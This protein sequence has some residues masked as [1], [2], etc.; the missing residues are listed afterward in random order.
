[1]STSEIQPAG[2]K[3]RQKF[4]RGR[5]A[6]TALDPQPSD[7]PEDPLNWPQWKKD[8]AFGS[9]VLGTAVTGMYKT[10]LVTVGSVLRFQLD[11][12]WIGITALTGL[13]IMLGGL[14]GLKSIA[15][16]QLIGKRLLY[17]L[18]ALLL[19][20]S[21]YW[22]MH[23]TGSYA[24]FMMSRVLAGICWGTY[25][26]LINMSMK[27][28][29]FVH[30]RSSRIAILNVTSIIFTWGSP[31]IGGFISQR[32]DGFHN[33]VKIV[34]IIQS[35]SIIFL[36]LIT[37]ETTFKRAA[38]NSRSTVAVE[39]TI[40]TT[41]PACVGLKLY[42]QS[43]RPIHPNAKSKFQLSKALLPFRALC[44]PTVILTFLMT[45]PLV[46]SAFA[47]ALIIALLFS[48]SPI[49]ALPTQIGLMFT[50]PL[51]ASLIAYG[52]AALAAHIR[53]RPPNHISATCQNHLGIA[54]PG[55]VLGFSGILGFGLYVE[56][57][58]RPVTRK[59]GEVFALYVQGRD[60]N[61][62]IASLLFGLLVSGA[63]LINFSASNHMRA[64]TS[65]VESDV[66][67]GAHTTLQNLLTGI[68]VIG[69][70]IWIDGN[71]GMSFPGLKNAA[72]ALGVVQIFISS[73]VTALLWICGDAIS[74]LDGRVLGRKAATEEDGFRTHQRWKSTDSFFDG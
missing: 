30:E 21:G 54:I 27:D 42:L 32:S 20:G 22:T 34:N 52:V 36:M 40:T 6:S 10:M 13:P 65:S 62:N 60:F 56:E 48:P 47:T 71:G 5:N 38:A 66:V 55:L 1:M 2:E 8:I 33:Q 35:F 29:Y 73:S 61:E 58:L 43:L 70:P 45:G 67:E 46:A 12:N 23:V 19:L 41:A 39:T 69:M 53:S 28:I 16:S 51:V 14:A 72:I 18:S 3:T 59:A 31:M 64:T 15:I 25:E 63:V 9:L 68:F 4:S 57:I 44:A 24:E 17:I 49:L 37:P 26:T 74:R 50:G 7:S 11:T